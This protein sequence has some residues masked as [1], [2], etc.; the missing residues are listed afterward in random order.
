VRLLG[1]TTTAVTPESVP[2]PV[3]DTNVA[4]VAVVNSLVA[5]PIVVDVDVFMV[6]VLENKAIVDDAVFVKPVEG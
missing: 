2:V 6:L 4:V 1:S 5:V 3:I